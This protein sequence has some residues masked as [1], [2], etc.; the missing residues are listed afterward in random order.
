MTPPE[1][2][3]HDPLARA[4]AAGHAR[5]I[6]DLLSDAQF[7]QGGRA[8]PAAVL[9]AITDVP[10]AP[11]VILTQRPRAMRDHPGQVAFPGG[12]IDPGEDAVAAA[13]RE[14]EEELALPARRSA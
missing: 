14:A 6:P 10:E 4:F 8:T 1:R 7:A 5:D 3:L 12:K 13:L 11:Q 2:S 9:V